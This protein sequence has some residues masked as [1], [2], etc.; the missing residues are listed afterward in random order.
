MQT[1][2]DNELARI[3]HLI[4]DQSATTIRVVATAEDMARALVELIRV[5]KVAA[6]MLPTDTLTRT[7]LEAAITRGEESLSKM[8]RSLQVVRSQ[9]GLHG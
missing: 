7:Q 9:P 5:S 8:R 4:V 3:R 6:C 1:S 2:L